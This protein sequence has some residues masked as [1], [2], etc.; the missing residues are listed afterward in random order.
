MPVLQRDGIKFHYLK[1]GTGTPFVFQHGLGGDSEAVVELLD[2]PSGFNFVAMDFRG[3]GRTEPLG[4]VEKI[5]FDSFADDLT[6]LFAYLGIPSAIIGGNSMGA[7]VALNF[8]LRYPAK[9]LGLVLLRPAWLDRPTEE[10]ISVFGLIAKLL[11]EHGPE[12]GLAVFQ[13]S[14]LY[15]SLASISSDTARSL[16]EQFTS[17]R[18]VERAIRLERMPQ[19]APNRNRADWRN[20]NVP[21]LILACNRD[22]IHPFRYGATL[23]REIPNAQFVEV[24]SKAV[25]PARYA[26]DVRDAINGFLQSRIWEAPIRNPKE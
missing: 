16:A 25:D 17:P 26:T 23:A 2:P 24:T 18:A 9:V 21:A 13:Q 19:D 7:G 15:Q 10:N 4:D 12:R 22:P 3:H 11:R 8:A 14:S 1:K 5:G 6:A 20:I